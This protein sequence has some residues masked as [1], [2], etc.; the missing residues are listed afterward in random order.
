MI[1]LLYKGCTDLVYTGSPTELGRYVF[2]HVLVQLEPL[3][4][5]DLMNC[6]ENYR[7][8]TEYIIHNDKK[9]KGKKKKPF[10]KQLNASIQSQLNFNQ[11]R[12]FTIRNCFGEN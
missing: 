8:I 11:C 2:A 12:Q 7:H 10:T 6:M 3:N 4:S 5:M 9:I 1:L